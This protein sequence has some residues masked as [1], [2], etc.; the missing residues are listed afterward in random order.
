MK[1]L[2]RLLTALMLFF[3]LC[4]CVSVSIIQPQLNILYVFELRLAKIHRHNKRNTFFLFVG[5]FEFDNLPK[6]NEIIFKH[7]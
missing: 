4:Q 1:Q 6:I 7:D 3:G 2:L 5:A